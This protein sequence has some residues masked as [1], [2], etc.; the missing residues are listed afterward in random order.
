MPDHEDSIGGDDFFLTP[1]GAS[2]SFNNSASIEFRPGDDMVHNSSTSNDERP[3][4]YEPFPSGEVSGSFSIERPDQTANNTAA[5]SG[6]C[7]A[8]SSVQR[9]M[10]ARQRAL[11]LLNQ[12]GCPSLV[13]AVYPTV[14]DDPPPQGDSCVA[15][16]EPPPQTNSCG[17][18]Q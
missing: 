6:T 18:G 16:T 4:D 15:V 13:E 12:G 5:S 1:G 8:Q 11:D 7:P 10:D 2:D 17:C 3:S 14:I 9:C